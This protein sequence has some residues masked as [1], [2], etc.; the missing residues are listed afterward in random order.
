M[1]RHF[2]KKLVEKERGKESEK[3]EKKGGGRYQNIS[4]R[5]TDTNVI[6]VDTLIMLSIQ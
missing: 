1:I 6:D 2:G 5:C 4:L 3:V